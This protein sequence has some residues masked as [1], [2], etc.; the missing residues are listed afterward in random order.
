VLIQF[1]QL[2]DSA[3]N[4]QFENVSC[5][6]FMN[7]YGRTE[8]IVCGEGFGSVCLC[9]VFHADRPYVAAHI[10]YFEGVFQYGP[11]LSS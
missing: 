9:S 1:Y 4:E 2:F 7:A 3:C 5:Y 8:S 11:S 10:L 6:Q